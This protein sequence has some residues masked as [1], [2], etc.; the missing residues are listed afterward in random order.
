MI[1]FVK[2]NDVS[3]RL[4]IDPELI[5]TK[6]RRRAE[7]LQGGIRSSVLLLLGRVKDSLLECA[8]SFRDV[9]YCRKC[10]GARIAACFSALSENCDVRTLS[11]IVETPCDLVQE[12]NH[13]RCVR[14]V[15]DTSSYHRRPLHQ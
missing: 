10:N 15:A 11:I 6:A 1:G 13:L 7:V 12:Q 8:K 5:M 9:I 3:S 14:F 4:T 2:G